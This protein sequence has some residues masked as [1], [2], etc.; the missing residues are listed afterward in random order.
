MEP[1]ERRP[2]REEID[3]LLKSIG[4]RI[5]RLFRRHGIP[6]E[7]AERQIG[8]ALTILVFRWDRIR[9][10]KWWLLDRLGKTARRF[11]TH[12]PEEPDDEEAPS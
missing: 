11:S 3:R 2:T 4:P 5:D 8:E 10:P 6:P 7:E 9:N 12:S 1:P